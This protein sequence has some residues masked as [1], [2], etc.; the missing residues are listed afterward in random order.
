M[1]F[2]RGID[3]EQGCFG[4]M[5]A[6][7]DLD[8]A[9]AAKIDEHKPQYNR[10]HHQYQWTNYGKTKFDRKNRPLILLNKPPKA[11]HAPKYCWAMIRMMKQQQFYKQNID[12]ECFYNA[13]FCIFKCPKSRFP[14]PFYQNNHSNFFFGLRSLRSILLVHKARTM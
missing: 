4:D 11:K 3:E 5:Q 1:K 12:L 9:P 10:N 14:I 6:T 7:M 13:F 8:F 2:Y